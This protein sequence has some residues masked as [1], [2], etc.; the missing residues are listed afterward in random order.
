[1]RLPISLAAAGS[2]DHAQ[3]RETQEC[4]VLGHL[5]EARTTV[6]LPRRS[7]NHKGNAATN[8]EGRGVSTL[9]FLPSSQFL[10][11]ASQTQQKKTDQGPWE[12]DK[13]QPP[14]KTEHEEAMKWNVGMYLGEKNPDINSMQETLTKGYDNQ[15]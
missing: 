7:Q 3:A 2:H 1:M 10:T 6:E 13:G 14:C 11:S 4:M 15:Q 12:T 9:P 5:A 8:R